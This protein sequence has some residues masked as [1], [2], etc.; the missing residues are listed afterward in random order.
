MK[1]LLVLLGVAT[2]LT[3][4]VAGLAHPAEVK[5]GTGDLKIGAILQGGFD[6]S[7]ADDDGNVNGQFTFKSDWVRGGGTFTFTVDDVTLS[8]WIY[9]QSS[10][11]ETSDTITV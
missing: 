6:Y 9:D 11:I 5:I 2:V 8:G 4:G 1:R 7:L 10:N 3:I